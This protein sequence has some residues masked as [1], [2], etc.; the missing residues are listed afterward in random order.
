MSRPLDRSFVKSLAG[1][2]TG[3][4]RPRPERL[5]EEIAREHER[6]CLVVRQL[7]ELEAKS[8]AKLR[9]ARP[10]SPQARITQLID[11]KSIGPVGGQKTARCSIATS[12]TAVRSAATLV[13]PARPMTVASAAVSR[14]CAAKHAL[15]QVTKAHLFS[16]A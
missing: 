1:L 2:R 10:G 13:L 5:K 12:T 16:L 15:L 8:K 6:L 4:G 9:A 7:K 11:L 14:V 3:D